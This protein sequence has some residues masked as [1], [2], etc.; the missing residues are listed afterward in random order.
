MFVNDV[1]TRE[2]GW[3]EM[4]VLSLGSRL[5]LSLKTNDLLALLIQVKSPDRNCYKIRSQFVPFNLARGLVDMSEVNIGVVKKTV[6][7]MLWRIDSERLSLK[8]M[9]ASDC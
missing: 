8:K 6:F 3:G 7:E 1:L 2:C 9:V 4:E 5:E